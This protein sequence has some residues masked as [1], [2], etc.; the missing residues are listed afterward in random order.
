MTKKDFALIAAILQK[1]RDDS[2]ELIDL[3]AETFARQLANR[4]ER[5]NYARF[6]SAVSA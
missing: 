5:F 4:H 6:I 1:Y 3:M 2:P